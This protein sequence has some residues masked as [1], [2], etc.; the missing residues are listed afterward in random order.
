MILFYFLMG[1]AASARAASCWTVQTATWMWCSL[2]PSCK[3]WGVDLPLQL[4]CSI[5]TICHAGIQPQGLCGSG[6]A[7][8]LPHHSRWQWNG[9]Q[10][11][12]ADRRVRRKQWHS[13]GFPFAAA[14]SWILAIERWRSRNW[15][16]TLGSETR[17]HWHSNCWEVFLSYRQC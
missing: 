4:P 16:K 17:H 6:T 3:Q 10:P 9:C 2:Q 15:H 14:A 8:H 7:P 13:S 1:L 12:A 11:I 5:T